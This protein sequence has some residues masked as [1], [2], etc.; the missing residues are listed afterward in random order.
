MG[1]GS[2]IGI[3][4][5]GPDATIT[6]EGFTVSNCSQDSHDGAGLYCIENSPTILNCSFINNSTNNNGGGMFFGPSCTPSIEDCTVTMNSAG[7]DG[8]GIFSE[9]GG[10]T[11]TNTIVCGN[12]PNQVVGA[13]TDGGGNNICE[14]TVTWTVDDDGKADF[15]N[16]QAAVDA[17]SDGDEIIVMPGTY[18]SLQE[19]VVLVADRFLTI[20]SSDPSDPD[21]VATTIIDGEGVRRGINCVNTSVGFL[22]EPPVNVTPTSS[23]NSTVQM[24]QFE[25]IRRTRDRSVPYSSSL[26]TVDGFTI[27]N[28]FAVGS[29]YSLGGGIRSGYSNLAVS[30]CYLSGNSAYGGGGIH[31]GMPNGNYSSITWCTISNNTTYS[32]DQGN[33]TGGGISAYGGSLEVIDCVI[34]ENISHYASGGISAWD[35]E[36]TLI[37]CLI[38]NNIVIDYEGEKESDNWIGGVSVHQGNT[39]IEGCQFIGNK[40]LLGGALYMQFQD[41]DESWTITVNDCTFQNNTADGYNSFGYE[42]CGAGILTNNTADSEVI[43][44]NCEFLGNSAA[45]GGGVSLGFQNGNTDSATI[46][47][48][49][50]IGNF[51]TISGGGVW[52][53]EGVAAYIGSSFFCSNGPQDIDG[54]Y[55]DQ[56][57]N[58]YD[59][60]CVDDCNLNGI[61]DD[62]DIANGTSYDCDQN[63]QPDECQ[64]DCDGDGWI[65]ACDNEPDCDEDGIPDNC[66]TDCNENG[67]PDDCDILYGISEDCNA[68]GIPDECDI[69][70]ETSQDCNDNGIPDYCDFGDGTSFDCNEN[71][72]PDEC[73]IENGLEPDCNENWVPDA[74]DIAS[75]WSYDIDGNGIPD[76]CKT[77]CNANGVPDY[78]DL[79][80]GTSEDCNAN[81]IPDECDI[82]SGLSWD[83]NSNG[84]PDECEPDCND[85]GTVDEWDIATGL[86]EDVNGDGIPDDCQCV[87]DI[88]GD[89][90]VNVNDILAIVGYWGS[91]IPAGDIN[92]DGTVDVSDLLIVVGNWGACE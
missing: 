44:T 78:W 49:S 66:E 92:N 80:K 85:N 63:G 19:E 50:F 15:D 88:D 5:Y 79:K 39:L 10:M 54:E 64:P 9:S 83:L 77:D 43:I 52:I 38:Q 91:S 60:F 32:K 31:T 24:Q 36:L 81:E 48:C 17:S 46:A 86:S 71:N 73:D 13:Y 26:L 8:G 89:N 21:I 45:Y 59:E 51:A 58:T 72:I 82:E 11:I 37:D 56:G 74:C 75:G 7:N 6:I 28:G 35:T 69:A 1:G 42:A 29:T 22:D 14:T 87:A 65:D 61:P 30:N 4:C 12:N 18:T 33:E 25:G 20:R 40:G 47:G 27:V 2:N 16:I 68:N 53:Q 70:N 67:I 76:E 3:T 62:E 23:N 55:T 34:S 41:N 84:V 90:V 57:G